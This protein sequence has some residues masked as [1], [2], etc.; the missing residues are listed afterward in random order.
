M[1]SKVLL[2]NNFVSSQQMCIIING[3]WKIQNKLCTLKKLKFKVR[4]KHT[5]TNKEQIKS[6]MLLKINILY[7][8]TYK[9]KILYLYCV[10]SLWK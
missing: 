3:T 1:H 4:F 9:E 7:N 10:S 5:H 8:S 2:P 6:N